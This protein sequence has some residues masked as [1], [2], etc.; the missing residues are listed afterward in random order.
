MQPLRIA[1]VVPVVTQVPPVKSGSIQTMASLLTDGLV[2]RGHDVT[3][4]ATGNSVTTAKL[5]AS[6]PHGYREDPSMWPWEMYE[7]LNLAAAVE[8]AGDFDIIHYESGYYPI[9]L[10]FTR[11]AAAPVSQTLHHA[12]QPEEVQLYRHYPDAPFIAVSQEQAQ[13][14]EGLNVAGVVPHGIDTDRFTFRAQP[15]DYLLFLGRFTPGKGPLEAID[16]ARRVG[17]RL[18]LAAADVPYYHEAVAPL[19][20]GKDVVYVG[21]ADFERKVALFGGARAL[22]YP[23]QSGEP[24]GLVLAE[25]MACG[26][27]VAALDRGAVREVV[28]DGVTGGIFGELDA[29]VN[30]LDAVLALDR[31]RVRERAVERFGVLPMVDGYVDAF[32][33]IIAQRQSRRRQP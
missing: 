2:R 6:F 16:V 17:I 29:M 7:L 24:F 26:T 19:V 11:V 28:D 25:A 10:A 31:A 5:H 14:L 12:P 18:L 3:L 27:P 1:H 30:G 21:E 22:L 15:D 20:D 32:R 23:V 9:S 8:R 4:F 33:R 13:L